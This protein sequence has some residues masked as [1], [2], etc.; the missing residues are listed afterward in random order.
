MEQSERLEWE[1]I[2]AIDGAALMI[3]PTWGEETGNFSE[4]YREGTLESFIAV[5][6][7]LDAEGNINTEGSRF[8]KQNVR[9]G[10]KGDLRGLYVQPREIGGTLITS[11]FGEVLLV[12]IDLRPESPTFLERMSI[13]L[14]WEIGESILVPWGCGYGLL[15]LSNYAVI[16]YNCTDLGNN[17]TTGVLWDS[18]ELIERF[19]GYMVPDVNSRDRSFPTV[20]Q[21]LKELGYDPEHRT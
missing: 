9:V 1:V 7:E 15:I 10:V 18:P 6:G 21:F 16:H 8:V 3:R 2:D 20:K 5:N 13:R 12:V 11:V 14:S 4:L 17:E 19:S